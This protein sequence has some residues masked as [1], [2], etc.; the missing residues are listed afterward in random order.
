[1][2]RARRLP[3]SGRRV[4]GRRVRG[5]RRWGSGRRRP[6]TRRPR[7]RRPERGSRRIRGIR[8]ILVAVL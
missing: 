1:M 4:R 5:R 2:T 3:R 7:T 6:R 8:V